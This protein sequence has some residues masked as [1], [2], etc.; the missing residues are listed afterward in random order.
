MQIILKEKQTYDKINTVINMIED[1][2]ENHPE[3]DITFDNTV[4]NHYKLKIENLECSFGTYN[5]V[6]S[7]LD[8]ILQTANIISKR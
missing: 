5:D 7:A 8:L 3:L 4:T 2:E 6:I 1:I